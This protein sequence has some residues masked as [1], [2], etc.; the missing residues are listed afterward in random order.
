M[1][2]IL[3][4]AELL[5]V[6]NTIN[7]LMLSQ[8][9]L[10]AIPRQRRFEDKEYQQLLSRLTVLSQPKPQRATPAQTFQTSKQQTSAYPPVA[11]QKVEYIPGRSIK[12][13]FNKAWLADESDVDSYLASMR[14]AL[15]SE[16]RSGKRIQI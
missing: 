8:Q 7:A 1:F 12:V 6:R 16:I 11:E 15:L 10:A 13:S 3:R 4:E 9:L 14:E 5:T 2:K